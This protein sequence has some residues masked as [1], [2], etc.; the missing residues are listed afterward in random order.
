MFD[1]TKNCL[2]CGMEVC[3]ITC[4]PFNEEVS[5]PLKKI[6]YAKEWDTYHYQHGLRIDN[7]LLVTR[8]GLVSGLTMCT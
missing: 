7:G 5:G 2:W 8:L 4:S 3:D 6:V 1:I